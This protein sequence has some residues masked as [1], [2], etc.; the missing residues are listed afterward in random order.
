MI[1]IFINTTSLTE[2]IGDLD[3]N[4]TLIDFAKRMQGLRIIVG[5]FNLSGFVENVHEI[6]LIN[7]TLK[8][9][10]KSCT[11]YEAKG[12]LLSKIFSFE[13]IDNTENIENILDTPISLSFQTHE[14]YNEC[15]ITIDGIAFKNYPCY[16][17]GS[18]S[19]RLARGKI[20]YESIQSGHID[21]VSTNK[22]T[23]YLTSSF[24]YLLYNDNYH[25]S[26]TE[27]TRTSDSEKR[28]LIFSTAEFIAKINGF[29]KEQTL[30]NKNKGYLIYSKEHAAHYLSVDFVH[31]C[32]EV[33][34]IDGKHVCE[35]N[36]KDELTAERDVSGKHDIST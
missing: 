34:G 9:H 8:E 5:D 24:A 21:P 29:S 17:T 6:P 36:F 12:L 13:K 14:K 28:S 22:K 2:N 3:I 11:D 25:T 27:F 16:Y 33:L 7:K 19:S 20:L 23:N 4:S 32:F 35:I 31:G 15:D 30:T 1:K 10:I 18:L 26:F